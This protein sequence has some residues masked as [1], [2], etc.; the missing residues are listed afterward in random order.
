MMQAALFPQR[1]SLMGAMFLAEGLIFTMADND[2]YHFPS[3]PGSGEDQMRRAA[4]SP[5]MP[6]P[7]MVVWI[8][9]AHRHTT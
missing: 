6:T 2:R 8:R 9:A 3:S 4:E 1:Q 5:S 7:H